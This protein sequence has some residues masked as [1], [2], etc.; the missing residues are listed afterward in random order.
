M[1]QPLPYFRNWF[2]SLRFADAILNPIDGK[3]HVWHF[4]NTL[5]MASSQENLSFGM[6]P[7][8]FFTAARRFYEGV[9]HASPLMNHQIERAMSMILL[10]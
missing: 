5:L 1:E 9:F 4:R 2:S 6:S 7:K 8:K 10:L 3:K